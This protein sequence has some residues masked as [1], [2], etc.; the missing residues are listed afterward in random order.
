[1]IIA[2]H[3]G[4]C[5]LWHYV[6]ECCVDPNSGETSHCWNCNFFGWAG[7]LNFSTI[8]GK[9]ASSQ[10]W[11]GPKWGMASLHCRV[12]VMPIKDNES[13]RRESPFMSEISVESE[14]RKTELGA[15]W[16]REKESFDGTSMQSEE[17]IVHVAPELRL[18]CA[19]VVQVNM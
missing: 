2:M 11:I 10:N 3:W 15:S 14:W 9:W 5:H 1:M 12:S 13:S 16:M 17:H 4:L 6:K 7:C 8:A 18:L 19:R